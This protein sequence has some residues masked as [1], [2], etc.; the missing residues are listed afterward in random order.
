[1]F[2]NIASPITDSEKQKRDPEQS[3]K[4]I[5]LIFLSTNM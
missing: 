3:F 1:M 4:K 2:A 5:L